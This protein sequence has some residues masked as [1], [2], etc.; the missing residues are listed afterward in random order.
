MHDIRVN[1]ITFLNLAV[2]LLILGLSVFYF[3]RGRRIDRALML[4]NIYVGLW[5]SIV[6]GLILYDRLIQDIFDEH[7]TR[8]L[9]SSTLLVILGGKLTNILRIGRRNGN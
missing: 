5:A 3:L 2:A 8:Y 9:I 7:T 4:V 6:I 1:P